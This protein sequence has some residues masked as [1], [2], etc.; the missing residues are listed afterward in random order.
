M[1]SAAPVAKVGPLAMVSG[2]PIMH[3]AWQYFPAWLAGHLLS[4]LFGIMTP[5]PTPRLI[6]LGSWGCYD[7]ACLQSSSLNLFASCCCVFFPFLYFKG[8]HYYYSCSY[9]FILVY[10][11]QL[12]LVVF[13]CDRCPCLCC[14]I[15]FCLSLHWG[16]GL[17]LGSGY[18][19]PWGWF[20]PAG[21]ESLA[22]RRVVLST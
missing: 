18:C 17:W 11:D 21:S 20:H 2:L 3:E 19:W 7:L 8:F 10:L 4:G 1:Y 5:H 6:Y 15:F 22:Y 9:Y 16:G 13:Q 14:L 12:P